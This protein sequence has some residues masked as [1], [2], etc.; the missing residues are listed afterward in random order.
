MKGYFRLKK[1][2]QRMSCDTVTTIATGTPSISRATRCSQRG[3][4]TTIDLSGAENF[5][6]NTRSTWLI[7]EPTPTIKIALRCNS[8]VPVTFAHEDYCQELSCNDCEPWYTQR[9]N[10]M[11]NTWFHF[12]TNCYDILFWH[13]HIRWQ[14]I[15]TLYFQQK[16]KS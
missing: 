14:W 6:F 7:Q 9:G 4:I 11:S 10:L 3:T 13:A 5:H 1:R 15:S 16:K 12:V 8:R 2:R